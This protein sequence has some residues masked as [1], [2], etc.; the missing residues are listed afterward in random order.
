VP[1]TNAEFPGE[2]EEKSE[3][4]KLRNKLTTRNI[5]QS[6]AKDTKRESIKRDRQILDK[7][8]PRARESILQ[9]LKLHNHR[10]DKQ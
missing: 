7:T 1:S 2:L 5:V 4:E 6:M 3:R 10:E 9:M 8:H